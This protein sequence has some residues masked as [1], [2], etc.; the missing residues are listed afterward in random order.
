[1]SKRI[2]TPQPEETVTIPKASFDAIFR[3]MEEMAQD[4]RELKAYIEEK[5]PK[6]DTL[7]TSIQAA[8][9]C[10][11]TR[12]TIYTWTREK[13]IHKVVRKGRRGYLK[14]ELDKVK[15]A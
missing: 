3:T 9:Y 4:I 10:G 14:S 11:V 12:Q 13:R 6:E 8:E 7:F 1:M 15:D 2:E 5:V